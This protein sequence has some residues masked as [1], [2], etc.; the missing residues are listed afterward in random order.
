MKKQTISLLLAC[1]V[2]LVFTGCANT[3][4]SSERDYR[5]I[6]GSYTN[7]LEPQIQKAAADGWKVVS[8]GGGDQSPFVIMTKPK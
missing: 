4:R 3:Q 6:Y 7:P 2:A 5:V 1:A 8:S